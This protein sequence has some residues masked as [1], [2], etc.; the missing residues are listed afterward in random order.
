MHISQMNE[1][2]YGVKRTH[3]AWASMVDH[4]YSIADLHF[5]EP[6]ADI[7]EY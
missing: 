5:P 4:W 6:K 3:D 7:T 2:N 1:V